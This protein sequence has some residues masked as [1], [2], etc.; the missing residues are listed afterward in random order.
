MRYSSTAGSYCMIPHTPESN[1]DVLQEEKEHC[2][3]TLGIEDIEHKVQDPV[4]KDLACVGC[5]LLL[6][7][8]LVYRA[9]Y[10]AHRAFEDMCYPEAQPSGVVG[11]SLVLTASVGMSNPGCFGALA[12]FSD[13]EYKLVLE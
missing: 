4:Q 13:F 12:P 11:R 8:G 6:V 10:P 5:Q 7:E 3:G 9:F 1:L 2:L